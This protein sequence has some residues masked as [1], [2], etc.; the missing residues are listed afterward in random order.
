[1]TGHMDGSEPVV[2]SSAA[3]EPVRGA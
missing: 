1:V 3:T 2:R